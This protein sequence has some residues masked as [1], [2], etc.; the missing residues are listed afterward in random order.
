VTD[1]AVKLESELTLCEVH[2]TKPPRNSFG[3]CT[4]LDGVGLSIGLADLH[5]C[6]N[7][8]SKSFA[9]HC[10]VAFARLGR[11]TT[12]RQGVASICLG[13]LSPQFIDFGLDVGG[14][15]WNQRREAMIRLINF[16]FGFLVNHCI[17]EVQCDCQDLGI[18][19]GSLDAFLEIGTL[20]PHTQS[21]VDI[22]MLFHDLFNGSHHRKILI[23]DNCPKLV[24]EK[25]AQMIKEPTEHFSAFEGSEQQT[26]GNNTIRVID[27]TDRVGR[28]TELVSDRCA[29]EEEDIAD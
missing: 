1:G 7:T 24:L 3:C 23:R 20:V 16:F 28:P 4:S 10:V 22:W 17:E 13:Q 11:A 21:M 29:I 27:E 5:E 15:P 25:L 19:S 8:A 6:L 2:D 14:E 26:T 12:K 9:E 18:M